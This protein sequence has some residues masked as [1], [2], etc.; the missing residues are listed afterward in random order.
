MQFLVQNQAEA[1]HREVGHTGFYAFARVFDRRDHNRQISLESRST[2]SVHLRFQSVAE[3]GDLS[4]KT[5]LDHFRA[6]RKPA[7]L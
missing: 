6:R 4:T 5:D 3:R 2:S 1:V 7:A